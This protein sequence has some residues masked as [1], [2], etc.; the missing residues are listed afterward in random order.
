MIAVQKGL[1]AAKY[2]Q[3]YYD[4]ALPPAMGSVINDSVQGLFAG[5]LT[6]EQARPGDRRLGQDGIEVSSGSVKG[7]GGWARLPNP[8]T[9]LISRAGR[10][11]METAS[12]DR[13]RR[14]LAQSTRRF[15]RGFKTT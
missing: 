1:A 13:G 7:C 11:L 14:E 4:Q 5:T 12:A 3:L 10:V 8:R 6:P 9:L 2:F 15:P